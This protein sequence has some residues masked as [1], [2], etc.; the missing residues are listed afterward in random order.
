MSEFPDWTSLLPDAGAPLPIADDPDFLWSQPSTL[1]A[2]FLRL[3]EVATAAPRREAPGAA[4]AVFADVL[5]IDEATAFRVSGLRLHARRIEVAAGARIALSAADGADPSCRLDVHA[6]EWAFDGDAARLALVVGGV[7]HDLAQGPPGGLEVDV[8]TNG[9]VDLREVAHPA[10]GD[11]LMAQIVLNTARRLMFRPDLAPD[12][13]TAL[14]LK[15][16]GWVARTGSD[17]L[18][19]SDARALSAQ[20]RTPRGRRHSVPA[21]RLDDYVDLASV[22]QTALRAVEADHRSLLDRQL[23]VGDQKQ[24][25]THLLA[26]YEAAKT[27]A[28][29]LLAQAA[30]ET[31]RASEA[32]QQARTR[33]DERGR[34][35]AD[36]E[37]AF[38]AG[39]EA[40]KAELERQAVTSVVLGVLALGAGIALVCATG[41]AAAPAAAA[42]AA[43]VAKAGA[44]TARQVSRLVELLKT[45]AKVL[46]AIKKI[47]GYYA[48]LKSAYEA[49]HQPLE[50]RQR[51][52][53]A[54]QALPDPL[55]PQ[56]DMS[57]ADWA[58]FMVGLD[59]SFKPALDQGIPGADEF[60]L[61]MRKLAI[62]GKDLVSTQANLDRAQQRFQQCLWQT[63][64]DQADID[65]IRRRIALMDRKNRPGTVLMAY[66]AQLRDQLKFRL[67][68]AIERMADAYRYAAL[69]EPGVSPN[70]GSSGAELAKMLADI[71]QALVKARETRSTV[72]TWG[73][74]ALVEDAPDALATLRRTGSMS[75]SIGPENFADLER[76]RVRDIR[77]WLRGDV[78]VHK[79]NIRIGSS[80]D[81]VDRLGGRVFEFVSQPLDRT[82]RYERDPRG[83][84]ADR[85]GQPV[86]VT[87][88]AD[89]ADGEGDYFEPTALTTWTIEL[90]KS[91]NP[92]LDLAAITGV[93]IEFAGSATGARPRLRSARR[94]PTA[95]IKRVVVL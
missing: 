94:E 78:G 88:K 47:Q 9:S 11:A 83:P 80:G 72:S 41:G 42:G 75:W 64:R 73:P 2:G 61:A 52:E 93:A 49:V 34:D 38:K 27:F 8:D 77:V 57:E 22:T 33:L 36:K 4:L 39:I 76:I 29:Q 92:G 17:A 54:G 5:R 69:A 74:E 19:R 91:F 21:L 16:A 31:A 50:A 63:L 1:R 14:A 95:R 18:L 6:D 86:R 28:D 13:S 20:L 71:H 81:Y 82:F 65:D 85:W 3:G 66:T 30:E 87:L 89:H 90:P 15:M 32:A 10:P 35:V 12:F 60:L 43:Q 46:D 70:I 48:L 62:R 51:A 53:A 58:E 24:A 25:A 79:F 26:H 67:V 40:K 56:D 84:D 68:H 59:A 37:R 7:A 23:S 55:D 45:I 44:D